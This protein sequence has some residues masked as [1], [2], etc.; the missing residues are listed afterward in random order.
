MKQLVKEVKINPINLTESGINRAKYLDG[1]W[2]EE[3]SISFIHPRAFNIGGKTRYIVAFKA[4]DKNKNSYHQPV[5]ETTDV[6]SAM[7][8]YNNAYIL[9]NFALIMN[10]KYKGGQYEYKPILTSKQIDQKITEEF[11]LKAKDLKVNLFGFDELEDYC[12]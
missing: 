6:N 11:G 9:K 10:K 8:V 5:Y 2:N 1:F 12:G 7:F 3:E 4:I